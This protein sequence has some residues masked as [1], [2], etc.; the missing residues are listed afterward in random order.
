MT[1]NLPDG[2]HTV[3][4]GDVVRNVRDA[5]QDPLDAGIERYV[6]LE[7]VE[8]ENL[9]IKSWGLVAD[10]TTFTRKFKTGQVLFGRRRAYQ[11]KVAM[12]EF[13][14][15]CSG[16]IM[17]FEAKSNRMLPDLLPFIVQ[18][19]GFFAEALRTSS[20][21]LSP[22][23]R[24]RDLA[25]YE[26]P[27]PPLNEQRRIADILWAAD[28]VVRNWE[29]VLQET[30]QCI[31][32]C[33]VEFFSGSRRWK[34]FSLGDLF[35]VQ[36]GKMLSPKAKRGISPRPYLGNAN[37][38]WGHFDLSDV[39]SM[40]FDDD[41][42][43]KFVLRPGDLLICEGGEVG[44]SAVWQGEI[45]DCCYQKALHRL[46]PKSDLLQPEILLQFMFYASNHNLLARL[47]GHS[48]IAHLTA[49]KLKGLQVPVPPL[50][51]Q[52]QA[53][54]RLT[55]LEQSR[56][57]IVKHLDVTQNAKWSLVNSFLSPST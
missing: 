18:S 24:W 23:T 55:Q 54:Q 9:H 21:S 50:D 46:R 13:G 41:E 43:K 37:V 17:V 44:R 31:D 22:R 14:G 49:V 38:Q 57:V 12:A 30:E 42:F 3:R 48:T 35:E 32:A 36:L 4:F 53:T 52:K 47:T 16:D 8:P 15:V 20:G 29:S 10:G 28:A 56:Q 2:W 33:R 34:R 40:D 45:G 25:A 7:H 1:Q 51:V 19:D 5:E 39:K 11:R 6:G 27:L 26:F